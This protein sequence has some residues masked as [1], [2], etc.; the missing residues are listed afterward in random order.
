LADCVIIPSLAEGFGFSAAE[1]CAMN[2]PVVV[3]NTT[4]LPEV[5]SGKYVL[6]KPKNHEAI[7]K[8]IEMVYNNK[9]LNKTLKKFLL[10]DNI[11]NYLKIYKEFLKND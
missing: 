2:K 5:V 3:S 4:S 9:T 6:V 8:G 11:N 10:K 1:A 7:A